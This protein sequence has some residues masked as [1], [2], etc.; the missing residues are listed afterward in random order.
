MKRGEIVALAVL[1]MM[2]GFL[3]AATT[4][5]VAG[6]LAGLPNDSAWG[7]FPSTPS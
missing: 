6:G 4:G 1:L 2:G 5:A 3:A 7:P